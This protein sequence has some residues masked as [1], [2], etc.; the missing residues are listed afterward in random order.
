MSKR[1]S[2][3]SARALNSRVFGPHSESRN[4]GEA[5]KL[6]GRTEE[7]RW[8]R[9]QDCS[10]LRRYHRGSRE[11]RRR[12]NRGGGKFR[13]R[14]LVGHWRDTLLCSVKVWEW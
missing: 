10:A 7:R 1:S 6:R 11:N 2:E 3:G 8:G 12:N 9:D 5:R 4:S 13:P 14:I